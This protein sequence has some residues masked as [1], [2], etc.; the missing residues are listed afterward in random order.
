MPKTDWAATGPLTVDWFQRPSTKRRKRF[1]E[2]LVSG[3]DRG[4]ALRQAQLD[5]LQEFRD[6]ACPVHW[7]GFVLFGEGEKSVR[8]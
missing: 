5:L 3:R 1:Y 2:H 4:A 7:A 8:E 6:S